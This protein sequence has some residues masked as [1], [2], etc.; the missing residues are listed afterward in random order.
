VEAVAALVPKPA[1]LHAELHQ[2]TRIVDRKQAQQ[3]LV[4][5]VKIDVLAAIPSAREK[6]AAAVKPGFDRTRRTP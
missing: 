6:T 4:T 5:S 3:N 2:F 1:A